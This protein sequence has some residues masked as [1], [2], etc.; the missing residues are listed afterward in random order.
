M[1][2]E[3]TLKC[4]HCRSVNV[5]TVH[6]VP[7]N[8]KPLL[9]S[10]VECE[11]DLEVAVDLDVHVDA[12]SVSLVATNESYVPPTAPESEVWDMFREPLK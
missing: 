11:S 9:D 1:R 12:T 5:W 8:G 7:P 3:V 6:T 10:C 2:A 4:P